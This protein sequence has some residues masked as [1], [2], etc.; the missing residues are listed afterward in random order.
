MKKRYDYLKMQ[1]QMREL[2]Q[3]MHPG[4]EQYKLY[5]QLV[6]DGNP[7]VEITKTSY[8]YWLVEKG[9]DFPELAFYGIPPI[10]EASESNRILVTG[11]KSEIRDL[12]DIIH[13]IKI[14]QRVMK[15]IEEK[16]KRLSKS[17]ADIPQLYPKFPDSE[18]VTTM[19]S[20]QQRV[21]QPEYVFSGSIIPFWEKFFNENHFLDNPNKISVPTAIIGT[22]RMRNYNRF[23]GETLDVTKRLEQI[24]KDWDIPIQIIESWAL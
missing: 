6:K 16:H 24:A 8:W 2:E 14:Y 3:S 13:G 23:G 21:E 19:Q 18:L 11:T 7:G 15:E 4:N 17:Q 10:G 20:L 9:D 12:Y 22:G 5:K 1:E